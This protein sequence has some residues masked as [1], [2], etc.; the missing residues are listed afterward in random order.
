MKTIK[1]WSLQGLAIGILSLLVWNYSPSVTNRYFLLG[2]AF[3]YSP[4]V[5]TFAFGG[6][7]AARLMRAEELQVLLDVRG[8][9]VPVDVLLDVPN[10][11]WIEEKIEVFETDEKAFGS[12]VELLRESV[13]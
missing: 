1:R 9:K 10:W 6:F 12:L 7:V 3:Q 13:K 2:L 4:L 8:Y 5:L 11:A